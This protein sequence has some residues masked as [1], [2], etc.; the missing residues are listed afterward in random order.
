[1]ETERNTVTLQHSHHVVR[2]PSRIAELQDMA[3]AVWKLLQELLQALTVELPTRRKLIQNRTKMISKRG[4]PTEQ[5]LQ[6]L[7]RILQFFHVRE[8]AAGLHAVKESARRAFRPRGEGAAFRQ[9][10]KG[11]V[12]FDRIKNVCV[13]VKPRRLR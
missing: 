6:R 5:S 1:M 12:D 11:V 9:A 7:I 8:K 10:I 4:H 2:V 13:V 3:E